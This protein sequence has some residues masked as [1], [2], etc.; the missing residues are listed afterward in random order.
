MPAP[1]A[2]RVATQPPYSATVGAALSTTP[3]VQL[4]DAQ[5]RSVSLPNVAVTVAMTGGGG[6]LAGTTTHVSDAAGR[7]SFP[8]LSF[9]GL[10]AGSRGL[11][12]MSPGLASAASNAIQVHAGP[13]AQISA[14]SSQSQTGTAYRPAAYPPAALV[15]DSHG[16][17]V[18]STTV[19]FVVTLGGGS[20]TGATATTGSSGVARVTSWTFGGA[21]DQEVRAAATGLT[22]SPVV[23]RAAAQATDTRYRIT[24]RYLTDP[25]ASQR[26]AFEDA[27]ARLEQVVTGDLPDITVNIA[28]TSWCGNT[29]LSETVDDLLIFVQVASIDGPGNILGQAAP[30][31]VR[32]SSRLPV[33]GFMRFDSDDLAML[34]SQGTLGSVILHEMMHVVGFGTIWREAAIGLLTGAGTTDPYFT[35]SGARDAFLNHNGGSLYAGIPVPVENTGGTGTADGHWRE[36][37]FHGELMTGWI[38]VGST[39]PMSRTTISSL[40]DIGYAVDVSQADPFD[41]ASAVRLDA[42]AAAVNLGGDVLML[43]VHEVDERTGLTRPVPSR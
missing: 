11:T 8:G 7:V 13:A 33:V 17:P 31:F 22:G 35:G 41:L 10:A 21:G 12:F 37:I 25:P 38:S 43:P 20:L 1:A 16:N 9:A 28:A 29:P 27:R 40:G 15:Q 30:C 6:S 5:G 34:E 19:T 3:V 2:L 42:D 26:Q 18:P 4:V 23:F 14:A 39:S 36:T 24:L 32:S